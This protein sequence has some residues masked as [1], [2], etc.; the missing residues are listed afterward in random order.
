ML[1]RV[2]DGASCL[3]ATVQDPV[4]FQGP[5]CAPAQRVTRVRLHDYKTVLYSQDDSWVAQIPAISGCY[6]IMPT[7]ESALAELTRVFEE[8]VGE[9]RRKGQLLPP[10]NTEIVHASRT[11]H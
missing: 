3:C 7:R 4:E 2:N 1:W 9:Y 6:A 11:R 8:I 5:R 10:D